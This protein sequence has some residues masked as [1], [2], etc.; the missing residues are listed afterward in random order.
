M[1][2]AARRGSVWTKDAHIGRPRN[3]T[4]AHGK[5]LECISLQVLLIIRT[6]HN[7]DFTFAPP[8][9]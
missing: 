8:Q 4:T 9:W 3:T 5:R 7:H 6:R 1:G 2:N